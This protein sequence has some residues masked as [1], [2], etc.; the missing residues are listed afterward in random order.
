MSTV[1]RYCTV[2][3]Y[4]LWLDFCVIAT[5]APLF[6]ESCKLFSQLCPAEFVQTPSAQIHD[7]D[8]SQRILP[9]TQITNGISLALRRSNSNIRGKVIYKLVVPC[10]ISVDNAANIMVENQ[11][12]CIRMNYYA[13]LCSLDFAFNSFDDIERSFGVFKA[14]QLVNDEVLTSTKT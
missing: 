14:N 6:S 7:P 13:I 2:Y 4:L 8:K 11:H 1:I 12:I 5:S 9:C 3:L 10:F